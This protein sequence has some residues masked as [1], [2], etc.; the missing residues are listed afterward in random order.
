[1]RPDVLIADEPTTALD[2]TIQAQVQT[3][4]R[5]LQAENGMSILLITHDFGI[6]AEMADRVA[7]M[8][9]GRIVEDDEVGAIFA[10][11]AHP[12]TRALLASII[13]VMRPHVSRLGGARLEAIAGALPGLADLPPGCRFHPRCQRATAQCRMEAPPHSRTETGHVACWHP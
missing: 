12:Y 3:L 5:S 6:A 10:R 1:V 11:P 13:G 2:V 9:A 4:L 7:V 8:Y